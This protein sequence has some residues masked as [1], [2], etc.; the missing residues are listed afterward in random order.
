MPE[1]VIV[2]ALACVTAFLAVGALVLLRARD[3]LERIVAL[4]LIT[5]ICVGLLALLSY[6]REVSYYLDAALALAALSF[7]ATLAAARSDR[8]GG[9]FR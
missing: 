3:L 7:V 1:V 6:L 2:V 5:V 4:D 9:P 8:G